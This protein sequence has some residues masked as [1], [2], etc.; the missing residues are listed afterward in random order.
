MDRDD[1]ARAGRIWA[2][3][4]LTVPAGAFLL[5]LF[6]I[7]HDCGHGSFFPRR[8]A[9]QWVGRVIG[10][11]TLIPFYRMQNVLSEFP[12]LWAISRV[13][14]R[15]SLGAGRLARGGE[16]TERLLSFKDARSA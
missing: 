11:L 15:Q 12:E 13:S 4:L 3:L 8:R 1:V 16:E 14:L 2:G 7:Q 6:L 5:R 9:N 10:V